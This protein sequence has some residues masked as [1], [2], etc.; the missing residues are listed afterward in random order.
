MDG[1]HGIERERA[2]DL[3]GGVEDV[4]EETAVQLGRF[5]G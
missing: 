3:R 1:E 5:R 2:R 4:V